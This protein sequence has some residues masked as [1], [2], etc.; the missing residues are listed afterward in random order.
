L[1]LISINTTL[2]RKHTNDAFTP[3]KIE[4]KKN[5]LPCPLR[6]GFVRTQDNSILLACAVDRPVV[7]IDGRNVIH[8]GGAFTKSAQCAQQITQQNCKRFSMML[9]EL[10]CRL[11]CA[12]IILVLTQ[13]YSFCGVIASQIH[14]QFKCHVSGKP[15]PP[16]LQIFEYIGVE[17]HKNGDDIVALKLAEKFGAILITNDRMDKPEDLNVYKTINV[18]NPAQ[19]K[20]HPPT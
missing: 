13:E 6:V 8:S 18:D 19:V 15:N 9:S 14:R 5:D 10:M 3:N 16:V 2:K 4:Q 20:E 12:R 11:P 7:V 1:I 17:R